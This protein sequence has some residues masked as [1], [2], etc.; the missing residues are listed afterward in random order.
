LQL[1]GE[2]IL[3]F[4]VLANLIENAIKYTPAGGNVSISAHR[5]GNSVLIAVDDTGMGISPEDLPRIWDRLFRGRRGK[6][7][8]GLGLGLSFVRAIVEA[9]GGTA[10]VQSRPGLGTSVTLVFPDAKLPQLGKSWPLPDR[11]P[12][13]TD[14]ARSSVIT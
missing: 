6:L 14:A 8:R 7:E 13:F 9:H 11:S 4:R 10:S 12:E 1:D 2:P 3:L 5:A